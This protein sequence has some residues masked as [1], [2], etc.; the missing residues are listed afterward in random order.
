VIGKFRSKVAVAF[1]FAAVLLVSFAQ[2]DCVN[3]DTLSG[4]QV[5][6]HGA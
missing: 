2:L 6:G 1:F 3:A 4:M 5:L